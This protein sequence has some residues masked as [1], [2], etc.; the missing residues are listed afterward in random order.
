MPDAG[1]AMTAGRVGVQ[2]RLAVG[3]VGRVYIV[4]IMIIGGGLLFIFCEC[5]AATVSSYTFLRQH[6][7]AFLCL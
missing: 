1:V 2:C 5:H 6:N 7:I 4:I 3:I